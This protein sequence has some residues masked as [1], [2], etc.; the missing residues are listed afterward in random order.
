MSFGYILELASAINFMYATVAKTET[1]MKNLSIY[2]TLSP[3]SRPCQLSEEYEI[4]WNKATI[5]NMED[6]TIKAASLVI[7]ETVKPSQ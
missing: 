5:K 7:K 2:T 6:I 1:I 3:N 4:T